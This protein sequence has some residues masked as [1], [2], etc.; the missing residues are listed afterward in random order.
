MAEGTPATPAKC[1]FSTTSVGN[2]ISHENG[3]C[4]QAFTFFFYSLQ[5]SVHR[6]LVGCGDGVAV[7]GGVGATIPVPI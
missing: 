6:R 3:T 7:R 2:S 5:K 4:K 1:N